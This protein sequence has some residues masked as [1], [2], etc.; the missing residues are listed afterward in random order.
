MDA[1]DEM[2]L[3]VRVAKL[4]VIAE[5]TA[6][7]LE[8]IQRRTDEGFRRVDEGFKR[9]DVGFKEMRAEFKELRTEFKEDSRK[10]N[11]KVDNNFR[12]MVGIQ[13]SILL[14]VIGVLARA[15]KLV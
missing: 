5:H 12:W 1:A 9:V 11:D 3:N 6:Q 4:E 13:F 7:T 14:A 10:L 8:L 2:L 15:A